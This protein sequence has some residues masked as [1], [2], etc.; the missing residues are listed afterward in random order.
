M[1]R[2]IIS[3]MLL[4]ITTAQAY[5][6]ALPCG[7]PGSG[8]TA[9]SYSGSGG[10]RLDACFDQK[11]DKVTLRLPDNTVISLPSAI[12]ASGARYSDGNRTFWE[13][14]GAGRYFSGD[15]MLFEGKLVS[16][17]AYNAGVTSKV[18]TRT[19][20]T[21]NGQ[22]VVYPVTDKAEVTAL[23][24]DLAPA[25]ETGWHKHPVPVYAFVLSGRLAIELEGGRTL[26]FKAGD[27]IVEM[28][29]TFHNGRNIG[30]E[31]VRLVVFYTGIQG[32]ANVIRMP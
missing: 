26:Q 8:Q 23:L 7:G 11:A 3:A 17:A 5:A 19:G 2:L 31:P 16:P 27:A 22:K 1:I 28:V 4:T 15:T 25:A 13:H 10:E 18:L 29:D 9:A 6:T 30:I 24:V 32:E 20:V 21:S 14:Q 12:A